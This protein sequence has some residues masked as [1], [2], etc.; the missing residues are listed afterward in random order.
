MKQKY[1]RL[2]KFYFWVHSPSRE[3]ILPSGEKTNLYKTLASFQNVFTE[4]FSV[5]KSV[6]DNLQKPGIKN[7][8]RYLGIDAKV[9][10]KNTENKESIREKLGISQN[11]FVVLYTGRIIEDK[12]LDLLPDIAKQLIDRGDA[13]IKIHYLLVGDGD[14]KQTLEE[15][16]NQM[17]VHHRFHFAF[18]HTDE[19]LVDYYSSADCFILPTRREALGLSL[20]EA[21]SCSL[22]C[23]V[24]DLPSIKETITHGKNGLLVPQDNISEFVRWISSIFSNK[25][26][27]EEMSAEARTTIE[28]NFDFN[29]HYRIFLMKLAY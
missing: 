5:S 12:G 21:M 13:Y 9:F 18:A 16:I 11:A 3:L 10:K 24:T 17:G 6:F 23:V 4:I 20:L 27:R 19:E 7:K 26:I 29:R 2:P 1:N 22:P 15:K 28:E 8:V 14:Y 25:K